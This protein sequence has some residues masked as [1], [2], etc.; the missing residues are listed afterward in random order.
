MKKM[1]LLF[2]IMNFVFGPALYA[3]T[4]RFSSW[5][6]R[7]L[8]L[9]ISCVGTTV[10]SSCQFGKMQNS[11]HVFMAG[12]LAFLGYEMF[13]QSQTN[14]SSRQ[15][16]KINIDDENIKEI[17]SAQKQ[18]LEQVLKNEKSKRAALL[19]RATWSSVIDTT[20]VL[21]Q[22][23]SLLEVWWRFPAPVGLGKNDSGGCQGLGYGK[24]VAFLLNSSGALEM[25]A[26]GLDDTLSDL[27]NSGSSRVIT[28]GAAAM[29]TNLNTN[30]LND[31]L[32]ETEKKITKIKEVLERSV[33]IV[34][35]TTP[36]QVK[37]LFQN[38]NIQVRPARL[39][40][41]LNAKGITT[42]SESNCLSP[43]VMVRPKMDIGLMGAVLDSGVQ[44]IT[45]LSHLVAK[46]DMEAASLEAHKFAGQ[47]GKIKAVK[48]H[49]QIQLNEK[50]KMSGQAPIHFSDDI[51]LRVS[52]M[53]SDFAKRLKDKGIHSRNFA[54]VPVEASS[55]L[56]A[57][58][59]E[60]HVDEYVSLRPQVSIFKQLSNRYLIYYGKY[61]DENKS[62][63]NQLKKVE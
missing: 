31:V 55:Y 63:L 32:G 42:R 47:A 21:A 52:S 10:L 53:R 23:L 27:F 54:E 44:S 11:L 61:L 46:G 7:I 58:T 43:H 56:L 24:E 45:H 51:N 12:S 25:Q 38:N 49:L 62:S 22:A 5:S 14:S 39:C 15:N 1:L 4:G 18:N 59:Q 19:E 9:S 2:L 26:S 50:L 48:D 13:I 60:D 20:Y 16:L 57:D 34:D 40:L 30:G 8:S 35:E 37:S 6:N 29:I 3:Q 36:V 28:F 41:S 33:V 17:T